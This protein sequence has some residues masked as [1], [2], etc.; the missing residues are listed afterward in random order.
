MSQQIDYK[1]LATEI[2]AELKAEKG[3][4]GCPLTRDEQGAVKD[5]AMV[6]DELIPLASVSKKSKKFASIFFIAIL[7]LAAKGIYEFLETLW[8]TVV[9]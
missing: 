1:N 8:H 9:K 4:R 7:M 5:I 3:F 2:V 6:A